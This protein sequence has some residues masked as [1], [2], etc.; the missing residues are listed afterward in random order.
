MKVSGVQKVAICSLALGAAVSPLQ[1][2]GF[3]LGAPLAGLESD[4]AGTVVPG[5]CTVSVMAHGVRVDLAAGTAADTPALLLSGPFFGW[6]G[7]S[8]TY[9][10]RHFP[11]LEIRID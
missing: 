8:D 10:D 3:R 7:A 6:S 9:P 5:S 11:E 4:P 2:E 1:A